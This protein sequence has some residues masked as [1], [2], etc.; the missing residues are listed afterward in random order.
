MNFTILPPLRPA[1]LPRN[2]HEVAP[3]PG[4]NDLDRKGG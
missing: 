1:P 4:V 2:R 3:L